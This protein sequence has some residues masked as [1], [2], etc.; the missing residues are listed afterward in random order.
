MANVTF[1]IGNGLDLSLGLK[2]AYRDFYEHIRSHN[3]HPENK[4]YKAIQESPE[5]WADFEL[6][7]GQYTHYIEKLPEKDRKQGSINFHEELEVLRED[8]AEYL[9]KQEKY[10]DNMA[11]ELN[12]T[13]TGYF[14][15]L[16][17]GQADRI[18]RLL[19]QSRTNIRFV[20]LN[21]T[22][23]LEKILPNLRVSLA[24]QSIQIGNPHHIHGDLLE[25]LTLGVSDES[26]LSSSMSGAE[27]DDLIKPSLIYSM[28]D[29]RIETMR[30][31]INSSSVVVIFGASI[32]ETD[33]YIWEILNSWI[34]G[35]VDGHIIVHKHDSAYTDRTRRSSRK[36]KQF[37]SNVQDK[38]LRYSGL[39]GDG[40]SDL[41]AR[42]FVIHNTKKLF[43]T[44]KP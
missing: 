5:T 28:N 17:S 42:I 13:S 16:S 39:D 22:R 23:C 30:Q 14:E 24:N 19:S 12:F 43:A 38:I 35:S 9:E 2:T 25:N 34:V 8:L 32:G 4:I 10:I 31:M 7:L 6:A 37:T 29:G 21:Y 33:K 44:N 41:K 26:Q 18:R 3:L 11:N 20:T 27:K 40:I 15:E 36:Q 1:I